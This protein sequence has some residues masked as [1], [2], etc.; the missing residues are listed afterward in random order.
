MAPGQTPWVAASRTGR[1]APS[2]SGPLHLGNL[3]TALVAWLAARSAG[4][5]FL[6]RVDDLDPDR[7][8]PEH[9]RTQLADLL[10]IGLDWDGPLVRQSERRDRHRAAFDRLAAEGRVYPCWCTRADIRT[11]AQAPHGRGRRYPGTCRAL[12]PTARRARLATAPPSWRLDSAGAVVTVTDLIRGQ[13]TESVDDLVVWRADGVPA[14][15]LAVVVDDA[16]M[17]IGEVVRGDDLLEAAC[18]QA[19]LAMLLGLTVPRYAHVPLV[20]GPSGR[21]L[22]KRDGAVTLADRRALGESPERVAGALAASLG[23]APHGLELRP[24]ELIDG[25]DLARLPRQPVAV[26]ELN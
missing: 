9:E 23:L 18:G 15:T 19:H 6:L 20:L 25:F 5:A 11:A 10:A 4:A 14:Y 8:R 1:F 16:D 7:S 22:A 24:A 2:P 21:R 26:T 13:V 3:R 12:S 17:G